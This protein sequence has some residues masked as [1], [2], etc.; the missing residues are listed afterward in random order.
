MCHLYQTLRTFL[1]NAAVPVASWHPVDG[2]SSF[3][4]L[5]FSLCLMALAAPM[6]SNVDRLKERKMLQYPV[7]QGKK[8]LNFVQGCCIIS[9]KGLS[10]WLLELFSSGGTSWCRLP[11]YPLWTT[12]CALSAL[13]SAFPVCFRLLECSFYPLRFNCHAKP[14]VELLISKLSQSEN[15]KPRALSAY[16]KQAKIWN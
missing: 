1:L 14:S 2:C 10:G 4:W 5:C 9:V 8:M 15:W 7:N 6:L 3:P 16:I 12:D 11:P 13:A